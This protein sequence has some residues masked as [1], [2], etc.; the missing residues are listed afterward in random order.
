MSFSNWFLYVCF[1]IPIAI[2]I[3]SMY[4][5]WET[6]RNKLKKYF[7]KLS[8]PF[9][10]R[11]NCG[12]HPKSFS[13]YIDQFFLTVCVNNFRNKIPY[14]NLWVVSHLEFQFCPKFILL[15]PLTLV[16]SH[17][18]ILHTVKMLSKRSTINMKVQSRAK[19]VFQ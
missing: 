10:V 2:L 9:T 16:D 3:V 13:R 17:N 19:Y 12:S 7:Q 6:S 1:Y 15:L 5:G 14:L 8:W 11:I 18:V 4:M